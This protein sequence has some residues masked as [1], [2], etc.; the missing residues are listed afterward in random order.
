MT[1]CVHKTAIRIVA[2]AC[3]LGLAMTAHVRADEKDDIVKLARQLARGEEP[4][5]KLM[6]ELVKVDLEDVMKSFKLREK[7]R[8]IENGG[9][10]VG[11]SGS[12]TPDGIEA[13]F[14]SL[15]KNEMTAKEIDEQAEA[16]IKAANEA[17]VIGKV[18]LAK[19]PGKKVGALGLARWRGW[20]QDLVDGSNDLA[21]ALKAKDATKILKAVKNVNASCAN[22]HGTYRD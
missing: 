13:K 14:K 9:I 15:G 16:L 21:K 1:E 17:A 2:F 19:S 10:G 8:A 5:K 22:C 20:A 4:D 7:G 18:I 11:N 12:I 3:A 6:A